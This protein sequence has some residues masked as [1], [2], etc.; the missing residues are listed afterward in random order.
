MATWVARIA[1]AAVVALF[2]WFIVVPLVRMPRFDRLANE[3]ERRQDLKEMVRAGFE[4]SRDETASQRYSP[5]LVKEVIRQA[6]ERLSGLQGSLPL[7][8][9]PPA[10]AGSGGTAAD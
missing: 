2:A 8:G 1:I 5:E 10:G 6:V 3:I 9:P 4:F 7:P